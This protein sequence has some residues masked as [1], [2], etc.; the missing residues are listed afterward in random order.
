MLI[1]YKYFMHKKLC[2]LPWVHMHPFPD[3][4]VSLCCF[5][6]RRDRLL[7]FDASSSIR[8]ENNDLFRSV[9]LFKNVSY[10][11]INYQMYDDTNP[12]LQL[13]GGNCGMFS[14]TNAIK[15]LESFVLIP[16]SRVRSRI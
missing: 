5:D 12:F 2:V 10:T 8:P 11:Y 7:H 6:K 14:G 16:C 13:A 3:G 4:N 15:C 1:P 9:Y